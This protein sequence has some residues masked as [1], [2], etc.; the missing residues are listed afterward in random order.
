MVCDQAGQKSI[1]RNTQTR[2][3]RNSNG[4]VE[5][6]PLTH[7][8]PPTICPTL[9]VKTYTNRAQYAL[10]YCSF[11]TPPTSPLQRTFFISSFVRDYPENWNCSILRN[12]GCGWTTPSQSH[13]LHTGPKC[14][15][16]HET[17]FIPLVLQYAI[18]AILR[19]R[20][21]T[22]YKLH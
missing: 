18:D 8:R 4:L 2:L 7:T 13:T 12:I 3:L 17:L 16:L 21:I 14:Y 19:N 15:Y 5:S 9:T 6:H 11:N 20:C 22:F 10:N 1:L